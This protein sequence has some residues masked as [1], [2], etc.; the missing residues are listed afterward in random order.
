MS[1]IT[2]E[3]RALFSSFPFSCSSGLCTTQA[4]FPR[5][6][7]PE[8]LQH[9]CLNPEIGP[10]SSFGGVDITNFPSTEN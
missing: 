3:N 7:D 5:I 1:Q 2:L 4:S 6:L 9:S 10:G 8:V